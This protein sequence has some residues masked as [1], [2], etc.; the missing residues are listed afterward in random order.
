MNRLLSKLLTF[1][2]TA[3]LFSC[4]SKP[5]EIDPRVKKANIYYAQGTR[6]LIAKEYT[7]ALQNLLQ[8]NTL[9][10]NNSNIYNNLGMAYFFKGSIDKATRF[11]QGAIKLDPKNTDAQMNLATIYMGQNKIEQAESIYKDVLKNLTYEGQYRTYY[12][13]GLLNLKKNNVS[14]AISYFKQSLKESET[15][16]PA[17]FQLGN[18]YSKAGQYAKALDKYKEATLGVCYENPEP[19]LQQA[20]MMIKLENYDQATFKLQDIIERF[21]YSEYQARAQRALNNIKIN[22][23]QKNSESVNNQEDRKI[24]TPGF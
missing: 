4:A 22:E 5:K 3:S 2:I 24:L 9:N 15:Y 13:L 1:L 20:L 6:N 7:S 23:R 10:P 19:Q 11:V 12:N 18:I 21:P 8:A 14:S 17:H 16:C